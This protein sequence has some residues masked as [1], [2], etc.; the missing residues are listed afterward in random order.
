MTDKQASE[1]KGLLLIDGAY[2]T[3]LIPFNSDEMKDLTEHFI[4]DNL[5]YVRRNKKKSD[6]DQSIRQ[7]LKKEYVNEENG[8]LHG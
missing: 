8:G 5:K 4:K 6:L 2:N 7:Y 1:T 3:L